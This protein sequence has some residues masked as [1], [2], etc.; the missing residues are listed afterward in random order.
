[1]AARDSFVPRYSLSAVVC[2]LEKCALN[3]CVIRSVS[4]HSANFKRK[5]LNFYGISRNSAKFVLTVKI[6]ANQKGLHKNEN[7]Q[8][9]KARLEPV[10]YL[11]KHRVNL[12]K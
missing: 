1:M 9:N 5:G 3:W 4:F 12:M 2:M 10:C 6:R 7:W 8:K 11:R